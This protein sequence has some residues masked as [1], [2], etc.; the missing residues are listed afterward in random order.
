MET[1]MPQLIVSSA[2]LHDA[3]IHVLMGHFARDSCTFSDIQPAIVL[4][5]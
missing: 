2:S 4:H 3:E 5:G 1:L